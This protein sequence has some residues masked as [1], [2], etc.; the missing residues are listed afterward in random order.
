M[1]QESRHRNERASAQQWR[2]TT[3]SVVGTAV[4]VLGA[5]FALIMVSYVVLTLGDANPAN[6]ITRFVSSWA[7]SLALGF[8]DLFTPADAKLRV[9]VNFGLA[10][11]FWLVVS[12]LLSRVIFRLG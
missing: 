1:S 8:E 11:L 2:A 7:N 10:A 9:L 4:R 12:S 6:G 5:I 3:I